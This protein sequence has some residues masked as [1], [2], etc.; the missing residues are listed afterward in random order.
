MYTWILY[1][2]MDSKN[3]VY[4]WI[5]KIICTYGFYMYTWIVRTIY[6]CR[7]RKLCVH[8]DTILIVLYPSILVILVK[9]QNKQSQKLF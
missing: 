7:Y 9:L 8:M 3:Y 1:V 4:M 6:T 5:A 2:H